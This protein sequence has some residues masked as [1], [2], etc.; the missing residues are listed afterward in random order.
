MALKFQKLRVAKVV[1]ET[2]DAVS[3][4]FENPDKQTFGYLPGQY[5]TLRFE[6]NGKPYNRAFSLCSS[7]MLDELLAVTVKRT[8]GGMISP[9]VVDDVKEGHLIDVM[10]PNGHFTA[11]P[12]AGRQR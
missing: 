5:L 6:V 10:P 8:P 12:A 1:R 7:P 11:H 3:V 2:E 4:H 9:L